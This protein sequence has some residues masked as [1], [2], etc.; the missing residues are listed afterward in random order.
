[1]R[2]FRIGDS[3]FPLFDGYGAQLCG[4]RW[5]SP[6]RALIYAAETYAG[7]VLE[8]IVHANLNRLPRTYAVLAIEIPDSLAIEH[9]EAADLPGWDSP[10]QPVS[11]AFGNRWLTEAR[12]AVLVVPSLVTQGREHNVLLNPAHPDFPRIAHTPPEAVVWDRRLFP[13]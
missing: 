5:N 11:Q 7:A 4:G 9:L 1:M 6:G 8:I 12:S 10:N 2:C 13:E 3:R